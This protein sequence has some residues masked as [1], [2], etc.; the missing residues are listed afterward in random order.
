M[1]SCQQ[2]A[3]CLI[4]WLPKA[5]ARLLLCLV[6]TASLLISRASTLLMVAQLGE[7]KERD[8]CTETS[9]A[10][11]EVHME[12]DD[13]R[14]TW[15]WCLLLAL[16][17]PHF[18]TLLRSCVLVLA[19]W[20]E[21]TWPSWSYL[22]WACVLIRPLLAL[23][24]TLGLCLLFLITLPELP[25]SLATILTSTLASIP[26]TLNMV[27]TPVKGL[28]GKFSKLLDVM[29]VIVQIGAV[30]YVSYNYKESETLVW[31]LPL[32]L[33]L[34]SLGWSLESLPASFLRLKN[35]L[36]EVETLHCKC[37]VDTIVSFM[38]I[39][40]AVLFFVIYVEAP[41]PKG[42]FLFQSTST[43]SSQ[44]IFK[45][46]PPPPVWLKEDIS[47]NYL[48]FTC[49]L[50]PKIDLY[51]YV[52]YPDPADCSAYWIRQCPATILA[53]PS[54][55][56][57]VCPRGQFFGGSSPAVVDCGPEVNLTCCTPMHDRWKEA[58][59]ER[60]AYDSCINMNDVEAVYP[61]PKFKSSF[62]RCLTRENQTTEST[63]SM[64]PSTLTPNVCYED[65][66]FD[67]SIPSGPPTSHNIQ[68]THLLLLHLF[69]TFL[70]YSLCYLACTVNV[71]V[72]G[73][74]LP[75]FLSQILAAL[76]VTFICQNI[77]STAQILPLGMF[78]ACG[79]DDSLDAVHLTLY[80]AFASQIWNAKHVW[81]PKK[82]LD[83][84]I[85]DVPLYESLVLEQSLILTR[86]KKTVNNE[87]KEAKNSKRTKKHIF[88]C[89]TMWHET[90]KE[91]KLLLKSA[92]IMDAHSAKEDTGLYSWQLHIFFDD[93]F[94]TED[95]KQCVN[96]FVLGLFQAMRELHKEERD[97]YKHI[98]AV[99]RDEFIP[100]TVLENTVYGGRVTWT[101]QF[102]TEVICH[103]KDSSLVRH[104][105]R[106]SQCM[107]LEYFR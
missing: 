52:V 27:N 18:F 83:S 95:G 21:L 43:T 96:E 67:W 48:N 34:T 30:I 78:Y 99:D 4:T 31:S 38:K 97:F 15:L 36:N 63:S 65:E 69:S 42:S 61:F 79:S 26:S 19:S 8:Q 16:I 14:S 66:H 77:C 53:K 105:K 85:F 55:N 3:G 24:Q 7:N 84:V 40:T 39:S 47:G 101:L 32:G 102:N 1:V 10:R 45:P 11:E 82:D 9:C 56:Y 93:A 106:W 29:A 70:A 94:T 46:G 92:L 58:C 2:S 37:V 98:Q 51:F 64:K 59:G 57:T 22:D 86:H 68:P 107:Y 54:L 44:P 20:E 5:L 80:L 91:M 75:V 12:F 71:S 13:A 100:R 81:W 87:K 88:G 104:K 103:L 89:A 41:S 17:I 49:D 62:V 28:L 76:G 74:A 60:T 33:L 90:P 25:S 23:L 73:F 72:T 6:T 35:I 50:S